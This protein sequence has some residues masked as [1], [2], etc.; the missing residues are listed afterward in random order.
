[1]RRASHRGDVLI[2]SAR[3]DLRLYDGERARLAWR[4][5]RRLAPPSVTTAAAGPCARAAS[6]TPRARSRHLRRSRTTLRRRGHRC[7][8]YKLT[9]TLHL[10]LFY[11]SVILND[12]ACLRTFF[13]IIIIYHSH[14]IILKNKKK[15]IFLYVHVTHS[16]III[17]YLA[18]LF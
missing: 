13:L 3:R 17:L 6:S 10:F 5:A 7:E 2:A 18:Y 14:G 16:V 8:N 11:I 12:S 4:R 15:K 9:R 1:M